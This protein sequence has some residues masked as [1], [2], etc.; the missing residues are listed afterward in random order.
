M[1]STDSDDQK[2]EYVEE[3]TSLVVT[4]SDDLEKASMNL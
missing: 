2:M 1:M 4:S 3:Q